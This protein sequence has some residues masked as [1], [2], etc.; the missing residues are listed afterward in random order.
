MKYSEFIEK[1]PKRYDYGKREFKKKLLVE[2]DESVYKYIHHLSMLKSGKSQVV[3]IAVNRM[4][5][6][7]EQGSFD[8]N[9]TCQ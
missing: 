2:L 8:I 3:R 1:N 4:I 5:R 7:I 9:S 6:D